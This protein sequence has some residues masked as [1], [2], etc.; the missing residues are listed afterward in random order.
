[1]KRT[2]SMPTVTYHIPHTA[3]TNAARD[4]RNLMETSVSSPP[5]LTYSTLDNPFLFTGRLADT[6]DADDQL[7]TNDPYFKRLQDNRNRT[8]DPKHGRWLQRDPEEYIDGMNFY[9]YANANPVLL[10]DPLGLMSRDEFIRLTLK[11]A[12]QNCPE[13]GCWSEKTKRKIL[14]EAMDQWL[15]GANG[16]KALVNTAEGSVEFWNKFLLAYQTPWDTLDDFYQKYI[17]LGGKPFKMGE[18]LRKVLK[19][20]KAVLKNIDKLK[21]IVDGADVMV[22]YRS[23]YT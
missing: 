14:K 13:T 7:T 16:F 23:F 22:R 17:D 6:L 3:I 8:Y 20:K 21:V 5:E 10:T 19:N 4:D 15:V 11:V 9:L 18:E 12:N 2:A 1:M